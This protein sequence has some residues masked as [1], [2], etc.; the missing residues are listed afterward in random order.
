MLAVYAQRSDERTIADFRHM[1][2][3]FY[4]DNEVRLLAT[5]PVKF[6]DMFAEIEQARQFIHM[7]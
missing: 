5:G 1:G 3:P 2:I 7:D 6:R 4:E